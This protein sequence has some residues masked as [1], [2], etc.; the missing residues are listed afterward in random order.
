MVGILSTALLLYFLPQFPCLSPDETTFALSYN[1]G[2]IMTEPVTVSLIW[3]GT[4]WQESGRETVRNAISS[5]TPSR[6][7]TR[8]D[9]E[10]PT[11]GDW[12]DVVRQY[13]DGSNVPV[14]DRVDVGAEC[15]Y[16][17]P[18]LNMTFDQ[19]VEIGQTVFNKTALEGF[20]GNL[21][22]NRVFEVDENCVY[23]ILF[24]HTVMFLDEQKQRELL[25]LCSGKFQLEI[26]GK[27]T[28][29]MTWARESQNADDHC[30]GFI[31]TG[32]YGGPP[33][34]DEKIDSLVGYVLETI[35]DEVTDHDGSG[36][37]S[38]DG[39]GLTVSSSCIS[40]FEKMKSGPPLYTDEDRKLSF[41][42]VGLNGYRY[43]IPYI[44]NQK[45]KNCALKPSEI[46]S[47]N[48]VLLEQP[49]GHLKGGIV[50]N[51]TDGLQPYAPNQ[52]CQWNIQLP[53]AKFISFNINYLAVAAGSDDH[54][55]ICQSHSSTEK[56]SVIQASNGEFDKKFKVIG[57]KASIEFTSG[58][59]VPFESRGWELSYTAGLCD[60]R[61]DVYNR[62]GTIGY[63]SSTSFSYVEG[64]SCQWILHGK[65]GT[66]VTLAFTHINISKDLD[67]LAI[68]NG[69]K[70]QIA[71]FSGSYS[72]SDFR[73]MNLTGEVMIA[74]ATQTDKGEGWSAKFHISSPVNRDK[75]VLLVTVVILAIVASI[76]LALIILAMLKRKRMY[77][78]SMNS[79]EGLML[80]RINT[81]REEN[82][83]GEGPSAIVYRAVST[84]VNVVAVKARRDM[85]S[86]TELEEEIL[87][88]SSSH[89]NIV[90][91]LGYAQDGLRR[92][93]L[94]FEFMQRGSLSWNL[95]E[96]GG[97]LN[98]EKRLAIALQICS[99]I[100]MLHMYTKPP[101]CHGN[102]KSENI[103]LDEFCNAKLGGFGTANYCISNMRNPELTSE[104]AEDIWS[105]G[106]LLI[107]LLRGEL[108]ANRDVYKNFRSRD[109][110]N[111]FVGGQECLDRRLE[112]PNEKC[113]IIGLAKVGEIAKWCIGSCCRVEEGTENSPKVGDVLSSLRQV[114]QLFSS[115]L[116]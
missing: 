112:I 87:L 95:R 69:T 51:H 110:I 43:I 86:Q 32:Y 36:W 22:C 111:D 68:Y 114:K 61:E 4:G 81:G 20:G 6:Y 38:N 37:T 76:S 101:I 74:F 85:A 108:I 18:Q 11:L 107:E 62:D 1:G 84:N 93:Y 34:G 94:V 90:S 55:L 82:R 79:V 48:A 45:I 77:K 59:H 100:Q 41:N 66:L 30:S 16:T 88:K 57:S 105:F 71:N 15:F 39:T 25:D 67:F 40:P 91:L 2:R 14:T 97:T 5:L 75:N 47:S 24:S 64:L 58:D 78:S 52:K 17:G 56:C 35:A 28:V 3:F 42:A 63:T 103:L 27:M 96:R 115:A 83:I 7:S 73:Q 49:R 13:R 10:V 60:G 80:I 70:Q 31:H 92:R 8:K 53:N 23:H 109:R 19:V 72:G 9:S 104:M 26:F 33:N 116:V 89:P 44:W 113:K 50:V 29:N 65:P 54:L 98:W 46:C 21:N 106:L 99:A 102:I 12:W